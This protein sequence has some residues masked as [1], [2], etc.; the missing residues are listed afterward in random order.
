MVVSELQIR[1]SSHDSAGDGR[2]G[3]LCLFGDYWETKH[4]ACPYITQSLVGGS[5]TQQPQHPGPPPAC[6][7]DSQ[8]GGWSRHTAGHGIRVGSV[9]GFVV[10]GTVSVG[11]G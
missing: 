4:L 1:D 9:V 2:T 5:G 11:P 6:Q 8:T 3:T 10:V 7:P